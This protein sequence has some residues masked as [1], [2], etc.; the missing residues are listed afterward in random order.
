MW[1]SDSD[2]FQEIYFRKNVFSV[3]V[4]FTI[5]KETVTKVLKRLLIFGWTTQEIFRFFFAFPEHHFFEKY[6]DC[7]VSATSENGYFFER[8]GAHLWK[9]PKTLSKKHPTH[10]AFTRHQRFCRHEVCA[11]WEKSG[12]WKNPTTES[13]IF[14]SNIFRSVNFRGKSKKLFC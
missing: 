14:R 2:V 3:P 1:G 9:S 10:K 7:F 8:N 11:S 6:G 5:A 13:N 4:K 12:K